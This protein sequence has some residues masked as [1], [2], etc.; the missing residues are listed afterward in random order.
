LKV[1]TSAEKPERQSVFIELVS[2]EKGERH[3]DFWGVV[4]NGKGKETSDGTR[5]VRF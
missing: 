4:E 3:R 1:V 2:Q 5:K